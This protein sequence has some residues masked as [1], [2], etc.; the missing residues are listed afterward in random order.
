MNKSDILELPKSARRGASGRQIWQSRCVE[1]LGC[2][3][4]KMG[5]PGAVREVSIDDKATGQYIQVSTGRLFTRL[6]VNGRDYFF[7]RLTG[8]FDGTGTGC[9]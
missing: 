1:F 6:S 5:I 3:L 4:N 8:R 7:N 9:G 2:L